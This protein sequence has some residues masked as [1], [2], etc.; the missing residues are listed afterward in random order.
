MSR[1]DVGRLPVVAR[2]DAGQLLGLLRRTHII[3]AYEAA[4]ARRTALRSQ[5]QNVR[6]GAVTGVEVVEIAVAA[7]SACA[8]M[9]LRDLDWPA[10]SVIAAIR[11]R[12]QVIVPHG[13]TTIQAGDVLAVLG[14]EVALTEIRRRCAPDRAA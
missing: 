7:G 8:G 2:S 12:G 1:G 4:L 14:D 3:R 10:Q 11:R 9:R 5:A 13:S 6:M